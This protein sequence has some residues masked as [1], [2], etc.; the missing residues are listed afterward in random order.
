MGSLLAGMA[1]WGLIPYD[2]VPHDPVPYDPVPYDPA[3]PNSVTK[4]NLT[5]NPNPNPHP[6]PNR[7]PTL[8]ARRA[9]HSHT[10]DDHELQTTIKVGLGSTNRPTLTLY[11][12][13]CGLNLGSE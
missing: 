10:S 13:P 2:P 3:N 12:A 4:L 7:N 6:N 5:P 1:G 9:A 11:V 8:C